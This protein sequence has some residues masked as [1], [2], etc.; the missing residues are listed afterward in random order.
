MHPKDTEL[1][2]FRF[3][4]EFDLPSHLPVLHRALKEYIATYCEPKRGLLY[5]S[6][7][8]DN[9]SFPTPEEVRAE[10]PNSQGWFTAIEDCSFLGPLMLWP[11]SRT[12]C[13]LSDDYRRKLGNL[14]FDGLVSL[15]TIP[16]NGFI[17]RGVC[18]G[19]SDFYPNS[20][21]D[22]VPNYLRGLWAWA[23]SD[24]ASSHH[25][26]VAAK[27]FSS[28]LGRLESFNWDL[29]RFDD[30]V[31]VGGSSSMTHI[32]VPRNAPQFLAMFAMAADL[33]GD[34]RW[35]GLF[36]HFRDEEQATRLKLIAHD[37]VPTWLPWQLELFM[38]GLLVLKELDTD[39]SAQ[40]AYRSGIRRAGA[41]ASTYLAGYGLWSSAARESAGPL[42]LANPPQIS[43]RADFR[44]GYR[45]CIE[46]GIDLTQRWGQIIQ[47][48]IIETL[49]QKN[50]NAV[51]IDGRTCL[52]DH[53]WALS[54]IGK[55][56]MPHSSDGARV[57]GDTKDN[58]I[59]V[60]EDILSKSAPDVP[61]SWGAVG[62]L[63]FFAAW[64]EHYEDPA[65]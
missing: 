13:G 37:D 10:I 53:F 41:L 57:Q 36:R 56:G 7:L 4:T 45:K 5:H 44:A 15:W 60:A 61:W 59:R 27:I 3:R 39:A 63:N 8:G 25:K 6:P 2:R 16:G 40:T 58:W 38:Q 20:S 30:K 34:E 50:E 64:E 28:V 11:L 19:Q 62:M 26:S 24:L 42:E 14:I 35:L 49:E 65:E 32:S 22:Q 1:E 17:A 12:A 18:P 33:T 23:K 47:G 48:R 29:R 55:S 31:G 54:V 9:G 51:P 46:M 43:C 21:P 52:V